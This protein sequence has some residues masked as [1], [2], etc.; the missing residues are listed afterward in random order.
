MHIDMKNLELLPS[1][2]T[3]DERCY[4]KSYTMNQICSRKKTKIIIQKIGS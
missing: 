2:Q 1:L 3:E 4:R